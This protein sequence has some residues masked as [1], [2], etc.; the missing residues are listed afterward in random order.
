[1]SDTLYLIVPNITSHVSEAAGKVMRWLL[2]QPVHLLVIQVLAP[3]IPVTR[4]SHGI[5]GWADLT[6]DNRPP[7]SPVHCCYL[8]WLNL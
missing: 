6:K 5:G 2:L 3:P 4:V 8:P 7:L 1:M